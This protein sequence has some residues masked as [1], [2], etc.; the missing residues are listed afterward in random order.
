MNTGNFISTHSRAKAAGEW[1][2]NH[3]F[4]RVISTHSRAKAAGRHKLH[5]LLALLISTHSRAKAAGIFDNL[6]RVVTEHFNSQPREGGWFQKLNKSEMHPNFNSQ[7]REGGWII[8]MH[9]PFNKPVFQ[10]TAA[11]RRLVVAL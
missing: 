3:G 6:T 10:L 5:P 11:R 9:R 1:L 4:L 2:E 7:P 8:L